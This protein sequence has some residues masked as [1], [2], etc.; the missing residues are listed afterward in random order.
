MCLPLA[1]VDRLLNEQLLVWT[2]P[3][4]AR[5][6]NVHEIQTRSAPASLSSDEGGTDES[7]YRNRPAQG[8]PHSWGWAPASGSSMCRRPWP[9]RQP[10]VADRLQLHPEHHREDE[11][12]LQGPAH[13][14]L[15]DPGRRRIHGMAAQSVLVAFLGLAANVRKIRA[16]ILAGSAT[17]PRR[18]TTEPLKAWR[19]TMP[20]AAVSGDPDPPVQD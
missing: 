9:L 12:L 1:P 3:R 6:R 13:E 5:K 15:D 14:A 8:I 18:R 17:N 2:L 20:K 16:F 11:R 7:D 19:P 4:V 10:R